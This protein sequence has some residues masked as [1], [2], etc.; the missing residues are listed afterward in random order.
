MWCAWCA[1]LVHTVWFGQVR[2]VLARRCGCSCLTY[3]CTV[4]AHVLQYMLL[5]QGC[6]TLKAQVGPLYIHSHPQCLR[7]V[8]AHPGDATPLPVPLTVACARAHKTCARA[9]TRMHAQHVH[10]LYSPA[11]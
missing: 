7:I 2:Q 1:C 10:T 5:L 9:R 11:T 6:S 4:R 8:R 3:L